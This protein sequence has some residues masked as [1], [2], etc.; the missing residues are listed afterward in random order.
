MIISNDYNI[1]SK[2]IL[3]LIENIDSPV[4]AEIGVREGYLSYTLL[5]NNKF[6]KLYSVDLWNDNEVIEE[7]HS[8]DD[9]YKIAM[10]LLSKFND[11]CI[12]HRTLS[13]KFLSNLN[14]NT[15]DFV[16][17]DASHDYHSV[18]NDICMSFSKIKDN[19]WIMGH[20]YN[21]WDGV[22][23]SVNECISDINNLYLYDHSM[24]AFNKKYFNGRCII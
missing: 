18:K 23:S 9:N 7:S 6:L 14:D 15:L 24:W 4:G 11:R 21:E 8:H 13:S 1:I 3:N 22:T 16:Y 20:D 10:Q 12:I 19:G 5:N 2:N 17:I